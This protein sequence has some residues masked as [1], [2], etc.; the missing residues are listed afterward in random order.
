MTDQ[1]RE[2]RIDKG[3]RRLLQVIAASTPPEVPPDQ[4]ELHRLHRQGLINDQQLF[5]RLAASK[6][7]QGDE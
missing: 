3:H 4:A 7:V 2:Q 1:D 6:D 5:E